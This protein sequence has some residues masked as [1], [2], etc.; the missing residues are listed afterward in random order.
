MSLWVQ[1]MEKARLMPTF[2]SNGE[3]LTQ[4]Y[5]SISLVKPNNI[6]VNRSKQYENQL[7]VV[8]EDRLEIFSFNHD[9]F[10][11]QKSKLSGIV[12]SV[13]VPFRRWKK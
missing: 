12:S 4:K 11:N 3:L 6:F 13:D 5:I 8:Y 10:I 1:G 9:Y 2:C 7:H